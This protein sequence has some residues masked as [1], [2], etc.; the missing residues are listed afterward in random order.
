MKNEEIY[1]EESQLNNYKFA[2]EAMMK[3]KDILISIRDV[4]TNYAIQLYI[5]RIVNDYV[6][7][8]I[9][10]MSLFVKTLNG[11]E[12]SEDGILKYPPYKQLTS[13]EATFLVSAFWEKID[14]YFNDLLFFIPDNLF[15]LSIKRDIVYFLAE[16]CKFKLSDSKTHDEK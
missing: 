10:E 1:K 13:A 7:E 15:L 6:D 8:K 3:C 12:I 16:T 11:D 2:L 9:G 14:K 4:I 5:N